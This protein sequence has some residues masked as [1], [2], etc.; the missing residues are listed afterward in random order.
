MLNIQQPLDVLMYF[1]MLALA[2]GFVQMVSGYF[3]LIR[4]AWQ[5]DNRAEKL[6]MVWIGKEYAQEFSPRGPRLIYRGA[7][8]GGV[9]FLLL[10]IFIVVPALT[11]TRPP[12]YRA[13]T[14][15]SAGK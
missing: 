15:Y 7:A 3:I 5:S 2:I 9:C 11:G 10:I 12:L 6:K 13:G 1:I 4:E 8:I 14:P